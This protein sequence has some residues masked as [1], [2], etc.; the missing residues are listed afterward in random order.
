MGRKLAVVV[1]A[2]VLWLVAA[3]TPEYDWREVRPEGAGFAVLMPD[4]PASMTR[5]IQLEGLDLEMTMHGA[6]VKDVAYTVGTVTLPDATQA[7][8]EQVLA[9]MRRAMVGNIGGTERAAVPVAISRI[10]ASGARIG[11]AP[12]LQIEA[13]GRMRESDAVLLARFVAVDDRA[14]QAVV[15]GPRPDRE[16]ASQF[17]ESLRIIR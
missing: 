17:L 15:L 1:L 8:R 14:W 3:C 2:P 12:G 9:A 6:R 4:K 7:T 10:D 13:T 11:E 16:P 5:R